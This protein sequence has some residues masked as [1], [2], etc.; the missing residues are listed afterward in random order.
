MTN[1]T[2]RRFSLRCS[3]RSSLAAAL[4]PA[5]AAAG[6]ADP[7]EAPDGELPH[8]APLASAAA[9]AE[10]AL[11]VAGSGR[12]IKVPDASRLQALI[13]DAQPGDHLRLAGG[14]YDGD[15]RYARAGRPA[16]PIV[17]EA[18]PGQQ[19]RFGGTLTLGGSY[20]VVRG[21]AFTASARVV[22][23]GDHDRITGNS[24]VGAKVGAGGVIA[25][26]GDS[27]AFDRIDHNEFR[28]FAGAA[29]R[30]DGF[31]GVDDNQGMRLDHNHFVHHTVA[32]D[33]ESVLLMLT[34]AYGDSALSYDHN[35]F[36]D[37]LNGDRHESE[38]VSIKT[39]ASSFIANTVINSPNVKVSL[40][41]TN[42]SR[43]EDNV[44]SGGAS[45]RVSGDD[46]V[47][48]GN[49]VTGGQIEIA[50]GDG[51]MDD[52]PAACHKR[53]PTTGLPGCK[54]LH[55]S[56]RDTEVSDNVG[57]IVVGDPFP[58]DDLP[59]Q[60]TTLRNN[61]Q[62]ATRVARHEVGTDEAGVGHADNHARALS[63]ADVGVGAPDP[64]CP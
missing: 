2:T 28:Q 26:D 9:P 58:G 13:D 53:A 10:T 39:G 33:N 24:F 19:V 27:F 45:I 64:S 6:C 38:L 51:T 11:C 55:S 12:P 31:G 23:T 29:F 21:L 52:Q 46:N 22:L 43:V 8:G 63:E 59:A 7:G 32:G 25:T 3:L 44:L 54:G 5:L 37:V 30:S 17:I 14:S 16:A 20:G 50:A 61:A 1:Q 48:R 4:L 62:R 60:R 47:V 49:R 36:D 56:A 18:A 15:Y 40:R 34:D 57:P 35:L 41:Q 42:R